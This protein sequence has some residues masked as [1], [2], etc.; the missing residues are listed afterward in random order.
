MAQNN[1][2]FSNQERNYSTQRYRT[3]I[4]PPPPPPLSRSEFPKLVA[5]QVVDLT[6]SQSRSLGI[7]ELVENTFLMGFITGATFMGI[8]SLLALFIILFNPYPY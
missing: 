5:H 4:P 7:R 2:N 3:P 1:Q 8:F 6:S